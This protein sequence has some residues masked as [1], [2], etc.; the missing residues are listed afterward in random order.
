MTR[1]ANHQRIELRVIGVVVSL[2]GFAFPASL[3]LDFNA[4]AAEGAEVRREFEF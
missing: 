4:E 1:W 2:R 3:R